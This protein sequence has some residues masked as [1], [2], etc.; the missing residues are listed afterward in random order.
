MAMIATDT[1]MMSAAAQAWL[2]N[3]E[4]R[5]RKR[6][7]PATL[8]VFS[9][10]VRKHIEPFLGQHPVE[11]VSNAMLREFVAHLSSQSLSPKTINEILSAT[12]AIVAS[13]V[14]P[15]TGE[16][17]FPRQWNQEFIDAPTIEK[18]KQPIV[19]ASELER[20]LNVADNFDRAL[21]GLA[22]GSGA[23][24][25]ELLALRIGPSEISSC[26]NPAEATITIKTSM[27]NGQEQAPKT[28]NALRTIEI[29]AGLN[30]FLKTFAGSRTEGFLFGNGT[31]TADR[32]VRAR[33]DKHLPGKG[34]HCLRRFRTT[35]LR[36][37]GCKEDILRFWLGHGTTGLTD[38][39]SKLSSDA[40]VRRAEARKCG[41][42]FKLPQPKGSA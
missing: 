35:V 10:F 1:I 34:F 18:Q 28:K 19:T 30:D 24:I 41:L 13:C 26:W 11:S 31:S 33:L 39:Y 22:A 8:K 29:T 42:G 3:L 32:T 9:S 4:T 5:K 17:L 27:W 6:A 20:T 12:K 37:T 25:G 16:A 21:L 2:F 36:G 23:R 40:K 15:E 14:D 38:I 7:K